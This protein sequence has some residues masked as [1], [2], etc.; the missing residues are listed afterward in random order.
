MGA[1]E[2]SERDVLAEVM[3]LERVRKTVIVCDKHETRIAYSEQGDTHED[4]TTCFPIPDFHM[5]GPA[6][7]TWMRICPSQMVAANLCLPN[8]AM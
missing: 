6:D 3:M 5:S 7:A 8:L 1:D 2:E 4:S